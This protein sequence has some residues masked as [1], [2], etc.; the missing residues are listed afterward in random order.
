M[1]SVLVRGSLGELAPHEPEVNA[2]RLVFAQEMERPKAVREMQARGPATVA[3][4]GAETSLRYGARG[5]PWSIQARVA[6]S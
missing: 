2:V 3:R 1:Q 6:A 5:E 4:L